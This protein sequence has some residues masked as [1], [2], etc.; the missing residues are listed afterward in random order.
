MSFLVSSLPFSFLT[1]SSVFFSSH[2]STSYIVT[3]PIFYSSRLFTS[4]SYRLHVSHLMFSSRLTFSITFS[5]LLFL[6]HL[7]FSSDLIPF[8]TSH[9]LFSLTSH[10]FYVRLFSSLFSFLFFSQLVSSCFPSHLFLLTVVISLSFTR[11]LALMNGAVRCGSRGV[12]PYTSSS[13]RSFVQEC[14]PDARVCLF[15]CLF[16]WVDL[17][18]PEHCLL[19]DIFHTISHRR[20]F[21]RLFCNS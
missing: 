20:V 7:L 3:S 18:K 13:K 19:T 4:L 21:V 1:L 14:L 10:L 11:S 2:I 9:L 12:V 16:L 6:S 15:V 8:S 17:I 5:S